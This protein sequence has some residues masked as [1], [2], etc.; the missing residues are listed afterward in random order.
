MR[1]NHDDNHRHRPVQ[2]VRNSPTMRDLKAVRS[3]LRQYLTGLAAP[4]F[5]EDFERPQRTYDNETRARAEQ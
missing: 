2:L 3:T 5:V 1:R 4:N